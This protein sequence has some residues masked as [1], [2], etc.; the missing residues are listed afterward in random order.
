MSRR[1]L[2]RR[3][4]MSD[5]AR[6]TPSPLPLSRCRGRGAI[7][8]ACEATEV[9]PRSV[10]PRPRSGRGDGGEG[11]R[12]GR[13]IFAIAATCAL[14]ACTLGPDYKRPP[15]EMPAGWRMGPA[16]A[17]ET[18]NAAWWDA[19]QDPALSRLVSD[20]IAGSLDLK[21]AACNRAPGCRRRARR[22]PRSR[23]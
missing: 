12:T 21:A 4:E 17:A 7:Q 11:L 19:F 1:A 10:A 9:G 13:V 20:A 16:E 2:Q 23:K 15:L 3:P 5:F 18:S 8:R 22:S 6:A 14:A